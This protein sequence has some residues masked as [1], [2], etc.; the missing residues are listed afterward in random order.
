MPAP[1]MI[2]RNH[3]RV[4]FLGDS[5]T[6]A[7]LYTNYVESYLSGRFP[8]LNLSFFNAG[9]NGDTAPGGLG[10][11]ER[12]VLALNPTVVIICYGMNDAAYT[13]PNDHLLTTYTGAMKKIMAR[14]KSHKIRAVILTSGFAD[15]AANAN[16]AAVRYNASGLRV[17]ADAALDLAKRARVPAYDLLK[18]M[19]GVNL[20]ARAANPKFG[21]TTDGVHPTPT[22]HLVMAFGVLQALRV[23][24]RQQR[25]VINL[26]NGSIECSEGVSVCDWRLEGASLNMTMTLDRLP[27]FVDTPAREVLPYVPFQDT[28]NALN[29]SVRGLTAENACLRTGTIRSPLLTHEE[30]EQGVNIFQLWALQPVQAAQRLHRFTQEKDQ[31]YFKAWRILGLSAGNGAGYMREPHIAGMRACLQFEKARKKVALGPERCFKIALHEGAGEGQIVGPEQFISQWSLRGP[32]PS[33][34]RQAHI[35]DEAEFTASVPVLDKRWIGYDLNT[36]NPAAALQEVFGPICD[37]VAYAVCFIESPV[38]Q[39]AILKLG[40][41]DGLAAWLNGAGL[42]DTLT[43]MRP[44]VVDQDCAPVTLRRGRN[45]LLLKIAQGGGMWGFCARFQGLAAPIICERTPQGGTRARR[46]DPAAGKAAT[47]KNT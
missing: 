18:L 21:M 24:P 45:V 29:V 16:L 2:L 44:L 25:V 27:F 47:E 30:L 3:D 42:L 38:D 8:E 17:L 15:E 11:L 34:F 39:T 13:S 37:C 28:Y 7:Q 23:P 14:L 41:D 9:W 4:V 46:A 1:K 33:P 19:T 20:A 35:G 10:R 6:E 40:S 12:D 32:F 43:D 5:I 31:I 26:R 22:G 36:A